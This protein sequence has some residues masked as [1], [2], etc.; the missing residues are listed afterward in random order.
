M[1]RLCATVL[2][3]EDAHWADEAT[4]DLLRYLARRTARLRVLILVTYRDDQGGSTHPRR[5]ALGDIAAL[6]QISPDLAAREINERA[7]LDQRF[8]GKTAELEI[9]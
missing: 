6:R 2:V 8:A 1:R 5:L 9:E 3:F 7:A 4:C